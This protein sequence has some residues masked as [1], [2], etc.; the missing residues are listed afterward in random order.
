MVLYSDYFIGTGSMWSAC[1]IEKGV[2]SVGKYGTVSPNH[3]IAAVASSLAPLS[4]MQK[5]IFKEGHI[6]SRIEEIK[7]VSNLW[8]STLAGNI[9]FY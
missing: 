2:V 7:V 8:A 1:P 9:K 4:V 5:Y 3:I 6:P